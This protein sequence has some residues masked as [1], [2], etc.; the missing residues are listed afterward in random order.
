MTL[1]EKRNEVLSKESQ[2]RLKSDSS[3]LRQLCTV[4]TSCGA[5]F[6]FKDFVPCHHLAGCEIMEN[7]FR[8]F[9][10]VF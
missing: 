6:A 4:C 9:T 1:L 3:L 2:K 10:L 7:T 8:P 5:Q